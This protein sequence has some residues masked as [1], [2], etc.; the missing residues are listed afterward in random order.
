MIA[1]GNKRSDEVEDVKG[2]FPDWEQALFL[3]VGDEEEERERGDD[4][5]DEEDHQQPAHDIPEMQF[6]HSKHGDCPEGLDHISHHIRP[7]KSDDRCSHTNAQLFGGWEN[8]GSLH[9]KLTTA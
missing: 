3:P 2:L 4:E 7:G 5:V 8:I 1:I 9:S 6:C